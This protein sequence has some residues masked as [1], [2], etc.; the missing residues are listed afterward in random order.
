MLLAQFCVELIML[1][2]FVVDLIMNAVVDLN[3]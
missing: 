1:E 2:L 3:L